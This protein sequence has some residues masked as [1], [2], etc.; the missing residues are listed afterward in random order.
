MVRRRRLIGQARWIDDAELFTPLQVSEARSQLRLHLFLLKR[1]VIKLGF[2]IP[3]EKCLSAPV[4]SP[5]LN[6]DAPDM[7]KFATRDFFRASVTCT[8]L[9]L[10]PANMNSDAAVACASAN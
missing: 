6:L 10:S 2:F 9:R 1:V 5:Q 7:Q 4:P 8:V 3:T